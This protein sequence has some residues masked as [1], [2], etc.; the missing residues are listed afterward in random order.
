MNETSKDGSRLRYERYL[1]LAA[2]PVV[3]VAG[4]LAAEIIHYGGP[5]I[6]IERDNVQ[7]ES[8]FGFQ[9]RLAFGNSS[10]GF[11]SSGMAS[12]NARNLAASVSISSDFAFAGAR[13]RMGR[14]ADLGFED[15]SFAINGYAS[16]GQIG[17]LA[18]SIFG[19]EISSF[20]NLLQRF[21]EGEVIGSKGSSFAASG[22]VA[23][24]AS[25]RATI[26]G[27]TVAQASFVAGEWAAIDDEEA[28]GYGGIQLNLDGVNAFG[29]VEFGWDGDVLTI[30]DWAY[31]TMGSINAGDT[32]AATAVPGGAGLAVLALGAAGLRRRR[33]R[34]G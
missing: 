20:C 25:A 33:K 27:H 15:V 7:S 28:R 12:A 34:I 16:L 30:Y 1:A 2:I 29:W 9:H 3:G 24:S 21:D 6:R 14:I 8:D 10:I 17:G 13:I 5:T 26:L 31:D 23:M 11:V 18:G 22:A 19:G 32:G 4:N